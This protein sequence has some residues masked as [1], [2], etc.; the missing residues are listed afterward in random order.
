M[1]ESSTKVKV[2]VVGSCNA[3]LTVKCDKSLVPGKVSLADRCKF[4]EEVEALIA[5]S[6]RREQNV[7]S[8]LSEPAVE[9][10]LEEWPKA[11]W[12]QHCFASVAT[13]LGFA[14][15]NPAFPVL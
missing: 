2:A 5:R 6:P 10:D 13:I 12:Q 7:R 14:I 15:E 11:N 8:L 3:D 4:L 1:K 9:T